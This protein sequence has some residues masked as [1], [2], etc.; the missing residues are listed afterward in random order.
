[1]SESEIFALRPKL[2]EGEPLLSYLIRVANA[3]GIANISELWQSAK[4]GN[5]YRVDRNFA[6][7]FDLYPSDIVSLNKLGRLLNKSGNE[8]KQHSFEPIVSLFYPGAAGKMIFGKKLNLN[9]DAFV[10]N[11]L[12]KTEFINYYGRLRKLRYAKSI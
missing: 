4:K 9:I 7:K 2:N 10:E 5:V 12:K 8:L 11:A 3:N 1:M 6:Y